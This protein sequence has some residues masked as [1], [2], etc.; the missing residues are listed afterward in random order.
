MA[1]TT[2]IWTRWILTYHTFKQGSTSL[3]HDLYAPSGLLVNA[4]IF[5]RNFF[6]QQASHRRVS[7]FTDAYWRTL[8]QATDWKRKMSPPKAF[9]T[10][11]ALI[12]EYCLRR[13]MSLVQISQ[14]LS[15]T[16]VHDRR[17]RQMYIGLTPRMTKSR[18]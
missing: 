5:G 2:G 11:Q 4:C 12:E 15:Y 7:A 16:K 9:G 3:R 18:C 10:M 1:L 13:T 17:Q 6:S 8:V 14:Q